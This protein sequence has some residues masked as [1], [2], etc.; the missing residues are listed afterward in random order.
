MAL[1][2]PYPFPQDDDNFWKAKYDHE[3]AKQARATKKAERKTTKT[4]IAKKKKLSASDLL[5]LEDSSSDEEEVIF[6]FS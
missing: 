6:K 2:I 1:I 3:A 5:R 4:G